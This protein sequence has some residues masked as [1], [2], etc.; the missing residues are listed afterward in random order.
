MAD[1]KPEA[2]F[3]I[4]I[5]YEVTNFSGGVYTVMTTKA[6]EMQEYYGQNYYMVGPYYHRSAS[7]EFEEEMPPEHFS[8]VFKKLRKKGIICHYGRWLIP[9]NP[10]TF[11]I[12]F[13]KRLKFLDEIKKRAKE[14]YGVDYFTAGKPLEQRNIHS[15]YVDKGDL[16]LMLVWGDAVTEFMET[17]LNS[18]Y[19]SDKLGALHFHFSDPAALLAAELRRNNF[20]SALVATAHSTRLGRAIVMH[21]GSISDELEKARK[22]P[23][24]DSGMEY[25]YGGRNISI[26]QLERLLVKNV[27]VLTAV[28]SVLVPEL[29]CLLGRDP[30]LIT[31]NGLNLSQT[32]SLKEHTFINNMVKNKLHRFLNAYFSPYYNLELEQSILFFTAGRYEI[33]TK[34]YELFFEALGKLNQRLRNEGFSRNVFVFLFI[35][36]SRKEVDESVLANL[37][38]Y[39]AIEHEI[40]KYFPS[41]KNRLVSSL[42]HGRN[43]AHE[44]LFDE[45]FFMNTTKL[46]RKFRQRRGVRP[47]VL[48]F[49][50]MKKDDYLVRSL[51][52]AELMN[53]EEDKVKVIFYP[54][55]VSLADSLLSMKYSYVVSGMHLG[56]FPSLYEPWGYTPMETMVQ[57]V[58]S[59]TSDISGFGRFIM[60]KTGRESSPAIEMVKTMGRTRTQIVDDLTEMMYAN[61]IMSKEERQ[62]K[63]LHFHEL[64]GLVDWKEMAKHHIHAHN[65][66]VQR[67]KKRRIG[68]KLVEVPDTAE[69]FLNKG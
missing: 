39:D 15:P 43:N 58:P 57:G 8:S 28:S 4:E 6:R 22:E 33:G 21:G 56:V 47:P 37:A 17:M 9:G 32:S 66:A 5:S 64:S 48:A 34:G 2:D 63:K 40:E 29:K 13:S 42:L 20:N 23:V 50:G 11:L 69:S 10:K 38:L 7:V 59:I 52:A 68:S 41:I 51:K 45:D 3:L 65:M 1:L 31:P 67:C 19:F 36:M 12:D 61:A 54:A 44:S 18:E 30:D 16:N 49:K 27:D 60:E 46:S 26:H 62:K 24:I 35:M 25:K 53:R 55:P 14:K